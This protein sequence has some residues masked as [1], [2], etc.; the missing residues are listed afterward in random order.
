MTSGPGDAAASWRQQALH[1]LYDARWVLIA[2]ALSR[3]VL[4]TVIA[5]SRLIFVRGELWQR[6]DLADMLRLF[7]GELWYITIARHGYFFSTVEQS[8]MPFFPFFPL[9]VWL[10]SFV[11]HD[12]RVGAFIVPHLSL[13]AAGLC[14]HAL[15]KKDFAD[16]RVARVAVTFLMFN[17]VTVF[18]SSAYTESTFIMLAMA[19]F[20][21][22]IN[23]RWLLARLIG[24]CLSATRN[25]GVLIALPLF[26]EYIRQTWMQRREFSD[27]LTPRVL[28]FGLVPL[29]LGAYILFSYL[30]FGEPLA[31][32]EASKVWGRRFT[33]PAET[34]RTLDHYRHYYRWL[35]LGTMG[36]SI[37]LLVVGVFV[38]VRPVY[39]VWAS[40]LTATYLCASNMEAWPRFLSVEFPLYIVLG[41]IVSRVRWSYEPLLA[42]SVGLLV[43]NTILSAS[44]FW[45]T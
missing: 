6:G 38:R 11:F 4:F 39:L 27:L 32:V 19:S 45:F 18:F 31:F 36:M 40:L 21:A 37:A 17:P 14:L 16:P 15:I 7:D 2:F 20:L 28:L 23:G 35:F 10:T 25:V 9:L 12:L 29:G 5:L 42:C 3:V 22:A 44:G 1:F 26:L 24:M 13:L 34:F 30:K 43:L 33:S 41:V 8:P